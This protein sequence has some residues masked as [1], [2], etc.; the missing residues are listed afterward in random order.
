MTIPI[1][2]KEF[3]N[4]DWGLPE[5]IWGQKCP[6][7][8]GVKPQ[9]PTC[10]SKEIHYSGSPDDPEEILQEMVRCK[11]CGCITDWYETYK[12]GKYSPVDTPRYVIHESGGRRLPQ[13]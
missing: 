5:P 11:H 6:E 4:K 8:A 7:Y 12:Q 2:Y 13:W 1:I 9:C 10:G 3:Y